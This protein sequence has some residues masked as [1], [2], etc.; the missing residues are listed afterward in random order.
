MAATLTAANSVYM[1]VIADLFPI[2][3]QLQGWASGVF[4]AGFKIAERYSP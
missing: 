2:P 1:L 4:S 3:Q